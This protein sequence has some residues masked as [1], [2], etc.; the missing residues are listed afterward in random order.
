MMDA[1]LDSIQLTQSATIITKDDD[2]LPCIHTVTKIK[3][4]ALEKEDIIF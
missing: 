4:A 2:T 1:A 3:L